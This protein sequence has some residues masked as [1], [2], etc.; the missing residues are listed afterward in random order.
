MELRDADTDKENTGNV[1]FSANHKVTDL[2]ANAKRK[3]VLRF[4]GDKSAADMH[5]A[6]REGR[7]LSISFLI[8]ETF[9]FEIDRAVFCGAKNNK[10]ER[11]YSGGG[12]RRRRRARSPATRRQLRQPVDV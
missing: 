9:Q 8:L 3:F 2:A 6:G 1:G 12:W 4:G 5:V 7:R 10:E 11:L